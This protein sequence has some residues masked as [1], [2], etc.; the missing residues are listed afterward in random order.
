MDNSSSSQDL[1]IR[2]RFVREIEDRVP[3]DTPRRDLLIDGLLR[4]DAICPISKTLGFIG[5]LAVH[6]HMLSL[7]IDTLTKQNGRRSAA[8]SVG[9]I[10]D[11]QGFLNVEPHQ[12]RVIKSGHTIEYW[13]VEHYEYFP[14][15]KH[16][17]IWSDKAPEGCR[18]FTLPSRALYGDT[19]MRKEKGLR[20]VRQFFLGKDND[21]KDDVFPF[22]IVMNDYPKPK[23]F[24]FNLMEPFA[25]TRLYTGAED[26]SPDIPDIE[27]IHLFTAPN[28]STVSSG[29]PMPVSSNNIIDQQVAQ[30]NRHTVGGI[31]VS[32]F[33]LLILLFVSLIGLTTVMINGLEKEI[34]SRHPDEILHQEL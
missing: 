29:H 24:A 33:V 27:Y 13:P 26:I 5:E 1:T 22:K 8:K 14:T 19:F 31:P 30:N 12:P 15:I 9:W 32:V 23:L 21:D 18:L 2:D 17:L 4:R 16:L 34:P 3:L 20:V 28:F 10:T 7:F 6:Q 11:L 25:S